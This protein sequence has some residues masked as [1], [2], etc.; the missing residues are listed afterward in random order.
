MV[1]IGKLWLK[2]SSLMVRMK[3]SYIAVWLYGSMVGLV[4][5]Q[6]DHRL[7]CLSFYCKRSVTFEMLIL[8][9]K[10]HISKSYLRVACLLNPEELDRVRICVHCSLQRVLIKVGSR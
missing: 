9:S 3:I 6:Q 1:R 2:N 8:R 4:A 10:Y 5:T 7:H